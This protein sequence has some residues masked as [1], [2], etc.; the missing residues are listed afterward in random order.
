MTATPGPKEPASHWSHTVP[1][2][3]E[4]MKLQLQLREAWVGQRIRGFTAPSNS[5]TPRKYFRGEW[6]TFLSTVTDNQII[7]VERLGKNLF[8]RLVAPHGRDLWHMHLRSTGWW[9]PS[10]KNGTNKRFTVDRI[11]ESFLHS[12]SEKTVRLRV[13]LFD[14]QVW[15]YHD[16]RT[17]GLWHLYEADEIRDLPEFA[18]YG[19]D[20]ISSQ[21]AAQIRLSNYTTRSN[22][23]V[24]AILCDQKVVAGLG[25]YLA[26]EI[27]HDARVF[28]LRKWGDLTKE[29]KQALARSMVKVVNESRWSSTHSH[30]K[31]FDK[32]GET[33]ATCGKGEI[34]YEKDGP[35]ASR[36]SYFCPICQRKF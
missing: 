2:A 30:W 9:A 29:G 18:D 25:N 7:G 20:V 34:G 14:G 6:A 15:N 28:P 8:V 35:G 22:S 24:K 16:S 12:M 10:E 27:A 1:E 19:P 11:Q 31:V 32:K 33:C 13:S 36:G 5:P 4:V 17:W 26:C 23:S 3:P 21:A